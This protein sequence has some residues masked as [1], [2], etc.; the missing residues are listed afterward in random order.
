MKERKVFFRQLPLD[1]QLKILDEYGAD[2]PQELGLDKQPYAVI[3]EDDCGVGALEL[4]E[5]AV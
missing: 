1:T 5:P 2:N 4:F 3:Y